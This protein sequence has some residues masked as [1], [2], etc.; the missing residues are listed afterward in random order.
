[1]SDIARADWDRGGDGPMTTKQRKMLNA[2]CGDLAAQIPWHGF[3][4]HKDD[5]RHMLA[6]TILGWRSFPGICRGEGAPGFI[7]LG[8]SSLS[9]SKTQARDAITVGLHIGDH[10]DEQGLKCKPVHWCD[11]IYLALGFNPEDFR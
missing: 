3:R 2:V 7:M 9:L 1:M 4:L 11:V 6:G 8:G 10:P 5:Y